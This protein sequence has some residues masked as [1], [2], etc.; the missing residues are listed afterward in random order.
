MKREKMNILIAR[1]GIHSDPLNLVLVYHMYMY[2]H[3]LIMCIMCIA[4][5][6]CQ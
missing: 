5:R 1:I 3:Q 6:G 4:V 2:V